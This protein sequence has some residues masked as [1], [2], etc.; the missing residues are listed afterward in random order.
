M[1]EK[2]LA[3]LKTKYSNLGFGAKVLDGVAS[4]LEKSVTDESQ[5]ET[6]VGGVEPLLKVFQS[7]A[8]RARTEYNALK[9]QYD[10]LKAK[11]EASAAG[12]GEQGKKNAPGD[13]EPA[14]FKAYKQ[15]QEERYNAI[16]TESDTLKAEKAKSERANLITAKAKELGIPEWRMKEGFV[17]ADDADEKAIGDY[18]AGVQKNLVT[19]GLEG[20]G[21]GFPMSTPETQGKELA[22]AWAETLPDKE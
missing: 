1:K 22:R 9:G 17:I 4:I 15:Q 7:D 13:E 8:D 12:G 6:A 10:V 19:A 5:I 2:I 3:A 14:W 11:V 20:K 18:L 16:K 21:S